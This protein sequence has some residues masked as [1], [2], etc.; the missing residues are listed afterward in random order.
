MSTSGSAFTYGDFK[1]L[2]SQSLNDLELVTYNDELIFSAT[3]GAME[4]I[5]PWCPKNSLTTVVGNGVNDT[6]ALPWNAYRLNAVQ[7]VATGIFLSRAQIVS[8][9][10]RGGISGVVDWLEYPRGYLY[11]SEIPSENI[12]YRLYYEAHYSMPAN[13]SDESFVMETP[14]S[15]LMGMCYWACSHCVVP[16]SIASAQIRQFSTKVDSGSPTDNVLEQSARFLRA[17]FIDEMNRQPKTV[18][19][20][21]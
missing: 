16:Y 10:A 1:E 11:M 17:L 3:I 4:A 5:L 21:S 15:A 8:G 6:F 19:P 9:K 20:V 14:K 2:V 12:E 13:A 18:L 7:S